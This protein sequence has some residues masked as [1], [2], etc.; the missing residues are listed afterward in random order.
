MNFSGKRA[1]FCEKARKIIDL[2]KTC[3]LS[4]K[5]PCFGIW[6]NIA[7]K[8]CKK[9]LMPWKSTKDNWF[10]QNLQVFRTN[11]HVLAFRGFIQQ[12][13][14]HFVKK[15]E[16][17][18]SWSKLANFRTNYHVLAFRWTLQQKVSKSCSCR[19]KA[20]KIIDFSKT[21]K[22]SEQTTMSWRFEDLFRK[23][24]LI[25]WKEWKIIDQAK[26]LQLFDQT[27]NFWRF[28]ELLSK[29]LQKIASF[30]E[31][32]RKVIDLAKTCNFS[33]EVPCFCIWMNF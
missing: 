14:P 1:S 20:R 8:S 6:M 13:V 11:Y 17:S 21:C 27:T 5:L 22:F 19:G 9:L 30:R 33:N 29:K 16:K 24:Y 18:S 2:A 3:N 15:H 10:F 28:R 25:S 7:G 32:E 31:K 23:K 4:N 12:K 26:T